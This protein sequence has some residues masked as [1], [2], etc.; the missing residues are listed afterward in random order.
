MPCVSNLKSPSALSWLHLWRLDLLHSGSLDDWCLNNFTWSMVYS[1]QIQPQKIISCHCLQFIL[2]GL[3]HPKRPEED[4]LPSSKGRSQ[5]ACGYMA[6][7]C[8]IC[9]HCWFWCPSNTALKGMALQ[10]TSSSQSYK[11]ICPNMQESVEHIFPNG[12]YV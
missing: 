6:L 7:S 2:A 10:T 12:K 11:V 9:I 5:L 1:W 8:R 4:Y 3:G